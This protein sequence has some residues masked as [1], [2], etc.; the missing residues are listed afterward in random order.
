[1]NNTW[2]AGRTIMLR[3]TSKRVKEEVDKMRLP[4]V[5]RL[6]RSFWDETRNGTMSEKRN[7]VMR[8]LSLMTS[9]C[10]ISTLDLHGFEWCNAE[11]LA[12][13]L[14]QCPALA[15]L[16]L[17]GNYAFGAAGAERL[18]GVLGKCREMVH[19]NLTEWQLHW[20]RWGGESGRN[21]GAVRSADSPQFL[22]KWDRIIWGSASCQGV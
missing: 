17:S 6:R 22:R 18:A 16:D 11:K 4:A 21:A 12:E 14:L 15:Y 19:L 20:S 2:A 9:W 13:V 3:R 1:M 10:K 5:V 7:H 8:Q